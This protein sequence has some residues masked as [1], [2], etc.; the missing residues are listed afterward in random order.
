MLASVLDIGSNSVLLLTLDV[1]P[2]GAARVVDGA[3]A[4]TR[5]GEDLF[6]GGLL[7]SGARTRTRD[8]VVAFAERARVRGASWVWGFATAA[9]RRAADGGSFVAELSAAA[10]CSLAVLPGDEEA[11]LAYAACAT[12]AGPHE[13]VLAVDVGGGT[14]ELTLGHGDRAEI[15]VS[16]PLGA[17]ALTERF[18]RTDPPSVAERTALAETVGTVLATSTL[19]DR[20][21]AAGARVIASGGS[22]T[23]LAAVDLGLGT[24][25][26]ARVHGHRLD[27]ERL[28][29]LA[30][31][32]TSRPVAERA[33]SGALDPDRAR[34]LPAGLRVIRAIVRAVDAAGM[35]VSELGVRHAYLRE[36]L[37]EETGTTIRLETLWR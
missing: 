16:L 7:T 25:E 26:P 4:T 3:L 22:A 20:A 30:D 14:T 1:P 32:L 28:A 36:R 17:L 12:L 35:R 33:T 10:G 34:I 13:P 2:G 29:A 27:V 8:A 18:V 5:L 6:E 11:R 31:A 15:G 9:A 19:I 23:A 24:Y 21:R 37:R